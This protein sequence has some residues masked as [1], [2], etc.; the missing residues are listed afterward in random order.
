MIVTHHFVFFRDTIIKSHTQTKIQCRPVSKTGSPCEICSVHLSISKRLRH[1]LNHKKS[2]KNFQCAFCAGSFKGYEE[3]F[4]HI[5]EK[6]SCPKKFT[7]SGCNF[8]Y[9][10]G[11]QSYECLL[12]F[13]DH[14]VLCWRKKMGYNIPDIDQSGLN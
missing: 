10:K 3:M 8:Y 11:G 2:L 12:K 1:Y 9:L 4:G 14:L 13:L 5:R 7:C 6:H